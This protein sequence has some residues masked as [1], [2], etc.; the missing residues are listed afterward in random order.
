MVKECVYKGRCVEMKSC[1]FCESNKWQREFINYI[2]PY[3][4]QHE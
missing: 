4:E 1:N 2:K 3:I